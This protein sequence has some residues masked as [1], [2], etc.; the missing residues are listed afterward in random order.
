MRGAV[1][2]LPQYAF[3]ARCSVKAQGQL[4]FKCVHYCMAH[5]QVADRDDG[6]Q[7]WVVSAI[8]LNKQLRTTDERWSSSMGVGRGSMSWC[9]IS[10]KFPTVTQVPSILNS[11][12]VYL[13]L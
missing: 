6:P 5:A 9:E 8:I 10:K 11:D 2:P 3:M 12:T 13:F 4:Y 1:P 7:T